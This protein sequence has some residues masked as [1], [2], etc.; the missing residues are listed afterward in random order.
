M[1]LDLP[2]IPSSSMATSFKYWRRQLHFI[3]AGE[4]LRQVTACL[5]SR[6][7]GAYLRFGRAD[8][9]AVLGM[10]TATIKLPGALVL[11]ARRAFLLSGEN[12]FK[13]LQ[14]ECPALHLPSRTAAI[15]NREALYRLN[16]A[17]ACFLDGP[18]YSYNALSGDAVEDAPALQQFLNFM[19]ACQPGLVYKQCQIRPAAFDKLAPRFSIVVPEDDIYARLDGLE[20]ELVRMAESAPE[21]FTVIVLALGPAGRVLAL[22][23]MK[24]AFPGFL[25][26][27]DDLCGIPFESLQAARRPG[28]LTRSLNN[29]RA[30]RIP[31]EE[32][33]EAGLPAQPDGKLTL[34]FEG[35]LLGHYSFSIINRELCSRF[36]RDNRLDLTIRPG[37]TPFTLDPFNPANSAGFAAIVERVE[38]PLGRA[39]QVHISNHARHPFTPPPEGRWVII[40]PWDYASLPVR[41]VGWIRTQIDEVWAPSHFV[42]SAFL[43]A[44]LPPER[45][46]VVPNGVNVRLYRPDARKVKLASRKSFKFLF[47][48]G[49]FWRKGF[50]TLLDA[51]ARAF[52]AHDEVCLVIKSAPEFWTD[53]GSKLLAAFRS[54]QGAPEILGI[55]QALDQVRMAGLYASCD[56]LVHPYRAE[57]FALCVAEAM[58]SALPV[59]VTGMGATLDFCNAGNA[60]LIP[61]GLRQMDEKQIDDMPTLDYPS[62]AEPDLDG[63]VGWMRYVYE[64]PR[65]ARA[66]ARNG[67]MKIRT[68]FTWDHAAEI[69]IQR[70]L[71]LQNKPLQR[72]R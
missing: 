47:V 48:G 53:N 3:S 67:M 1:R 12:I 42:R 10:R 23:L 50:D 71:A 5:E 68:E 52:S 46:A 51:Y 40:Q 15:S 38:E 55:I 29:F 30:A 16:V 56:C 65:E 7:P 37:D 49:P 34:R 44:G 18:V 60:F 62:Y 21:S 13:S 17:G 14:V 57:G 66:T 36:G 4:T 45:V 54:R 26:D 58:A 32:E 43:E 11:E 63:L 25:L 33:P 2:F 31:K 6:T 61:A 8:I 35:P 9:D 19:T 64:H 27:M 59:I 69:A 20:D 39:A 72:L 22:R 28:L 41:W 70:L 24:R